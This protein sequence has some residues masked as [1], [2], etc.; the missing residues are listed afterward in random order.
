MAISTT[1]ARPYN[2]QFVRVEAPLWLRLPCIVEIHLLTTR[3]FK[4]RSP[5][6]LCPCLD[7]HQL[8]REPEWETFRWM[9][10]LCLFKSNHEPIP[11]REATTRIIYHRLRDNIRSTPNCYDAWRQHHSASSLT[12][13]SWKLL[14]KITIDCAVNPFQCDC[15]W[16]LM[17]RQWRRYGGHGGARAPPKL[18]GVVTILY[19]KIVYFVSSSIERCRNLSYTVQV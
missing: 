11:L 12:D 6:P 14:W 10:E 7:P 9:S 17:Y 5:G 16:K 15:L 1:A 2:P 3:P 13:S 4:M 19:S 8:P 18:W